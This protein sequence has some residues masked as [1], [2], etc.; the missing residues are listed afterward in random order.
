VIPA[1]APA[2]PLA[3]G[4]S[5]PA[6]APAALASAAPPPLLVPTREAARLLNIGLSLFYAL[7]ASCRLLAPVHLGRVVRATSNG[8]G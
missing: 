1:T 2:D 3:P 8:K 4:L 6:A 7:K 5:I